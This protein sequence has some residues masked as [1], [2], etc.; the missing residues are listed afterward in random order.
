MHLVNMTNIF[1]NIHV[2]ISV[3]LY[4]TWTGGTWTLME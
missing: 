3:V 4:F 2:Y 1:F